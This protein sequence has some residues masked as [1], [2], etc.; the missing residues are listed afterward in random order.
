MFH[1]LPDIL[2]YGQHSPS[3]MTA[4]YANNPPSAISAASREIS[5]GE[6]SA[7]SFGGFAP[8]EIIVPDGTIHIT[9]S[10][11]TINHAPLSAGNS[12]QTINAAPSPAKVNSWET[13]NIFV[14]NTPPEWSESDLRAHYQHYGEIVS[15]RL[16]SQRRF[17]F[18]RFKNVEEARN[19]IVQTDRK[20]PCP[21]LPWMLHVSM[22]V[23][24][25]G[26]GQEP[27]N[28]IFVRGLPSW[29][30][31]T[32]LRQSV[33]MI[34]KAIL[35][36]VQAL[37]KS[38]SPG[39]A[40]ES[41]LASEPHR[42]Q[43]DMTSELQYNS[44]ELSS[45]T[46]ADLLPECSVLI[47]SYGRC[48]GTGFVEFHKVTAA[49]VFLKLA[50][51]SKGGFT[52]EGYDQRLEL[53]FAERAESR[54][55]RAARNKDRV[56]KHMTEK[57][58]PQQ[59]PS[60]INNPAYFPQPAYPMNIPSFPNGMQPTHNMYAPPPHHPAEMTFHYGG[61]QPILQ[62]H[63][64]YNPAIA[65]NMA[66]YPMGNT[67]LPTGSS[68]PNMMMFT[69]PALPPQRV[70]NGTFSPS[71]SLSS[72]SQQQAMAFGPG[73]IQPNRN[74]GPNVMY[75]NDGRAFSPLQYMAGTAPPA[76]PLASYSNR[77]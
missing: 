57:A 20:R 8:P 17:G 75:S 66:I 65:H 40:N 28:R 42:D 58:R 19:A 63:P 70:S 36:S 5:E 44:S 37:T 39:S 43:R 18:V 68:A 74:G 55:Q 34:T 45:L 59:R 24:D 29:C 16:V 23:H 25:E 56:V 76:P 2:P 77:L 46:E 33:D 50:T 62:Q 41:S 38:D 6:G 14:A 51:A 54:A 1:P 71:N 22:A 47:D 61:A 49:A 31:D 69:Q 35:S 12:A 52:L 9:P 30:T 15:V 11:S 72:S 13:A 73:I 53:K 4:N 32:H 27:N 10:S 64:F 60:I 26:D 7:I 21:K 48:K 67:N 3:S